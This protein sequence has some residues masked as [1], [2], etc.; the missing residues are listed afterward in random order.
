MAE[1]LDPTKD[2]PQDINVFDI[3]DRSD[4]P[5]QEFYDDIKKK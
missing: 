4:R 3:K 5:P 1:K 2:K